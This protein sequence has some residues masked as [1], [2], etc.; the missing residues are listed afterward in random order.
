MLTGRPP[1]AGGTPSATLAMHANE[2]PRPPS[3]VVPGLPPGLDAIVL[4]ALEK[5]PQHRFPTMRDL[6]AELKRLL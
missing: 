4:R 2:L 5:A 6:R 1:F 3:S